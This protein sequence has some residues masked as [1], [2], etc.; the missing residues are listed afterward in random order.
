MNIKNW[1]LQ[2]W[3]QLVDS[4]QSH[5]KIDCVHTYSPL[6]QSNTPYFIKNIAPICEKVLRKLYRI[7]TY[8]FICKVKL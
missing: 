3:S 7:Q 1:N 8:G 4:L 6:S 2:K 5:W